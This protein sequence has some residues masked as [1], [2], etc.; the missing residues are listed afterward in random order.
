MS[1]ETS[2][3]S[4]LLASPL[5][6]FI[7]AIGRGVG[8][9]QAAL[10]Q[11]S[12]QTMLDIYNLD[13]STN[14]ENNP[15]QSKLIELIRSIGYTPTFYTIP[16]T[17]CEAQVSLSMSQSNQGNSSIAQD[18]RVHSKI[19][20]TP[21]N[22]GNVNK[23]GLTANASAKIKFKV[24]AVPPPAGLEEVRIVPDLINKEYTEELKLLLETIGLNPGIILPEGTEYDPAKNYIIVSQSPVAK[25][26]AAIGSELTLNI[27]EKPR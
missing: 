5:G 26:T 16:E 1:N 7:A 23:F 10:D 27:E 25:T 24:V 6:D 18:K 13:N 19:Y 8:E 3:F 17:E 21:I 22:A 9:A 11:G 4:E 2:Q 15:D 14:T 20:A 12:L